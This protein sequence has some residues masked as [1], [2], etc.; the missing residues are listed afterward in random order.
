ML[1][2][3]FFLFW[4]GS[5]W[6]A[7]HRPGPHKRGRPRT[8]AFERGQAHALASLIGRRRHARPMILLPT[9]QRSERVRLTAFVGAYVAAAYRVNCHCHSRECQTPCRS[10]LIR[11][12]TGST[13][14]ALS[15]HVHTKLT[16]A[17]NLTTHKSELPFCIRMACM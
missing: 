6:T 8:T 14:V 9:N 15:I 12:F 16:T 17:H 3:I 11:H 1:S 2:N 5:L 10:A 13:A 7:P 4:R